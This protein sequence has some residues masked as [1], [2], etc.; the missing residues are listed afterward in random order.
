MEDLAEG[1]CMSWRC[2]NFTPFLCRFRME[3]P[4]HSKCSKLNIEEV[5]KLKPGG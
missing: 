3:G 2:L 5:V 1:A 4:V